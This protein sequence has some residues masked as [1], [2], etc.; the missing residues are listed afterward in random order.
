[1]NPGVG[2]DEGENGPP[3]GVAAAVPRG[4][5]HA[6]LDADHPAAES[7]RHARRRIRRRIVGD[8][9]FDVVGSASVSSPGPA[10]RFQ[11]PRQIAFFVV[12]GDHERDSRHIPQLSPAELVDKLLIA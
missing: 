5:D 6:L 7:C 9:D 4:A 3:G 1:V 2:V 10:D 8:D 12:C 11:Q